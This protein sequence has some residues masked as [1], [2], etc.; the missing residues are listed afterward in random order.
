[1]QASD[2]GFNTGTQNYTVTINAAPLVINPSSLPA[3][4]QG[5]PYNQT[6]S[7]SGGTAPYSYTVL[8]GS[9]P[10][11][12]SLGSGGGITGTPSAAGAYS[13]TVQATDA[14]PNTG[15]RAYTI[16]VGTNI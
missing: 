5:A 2:P 11:G 9:L 15:T 6:V 13:F 4:T 3:G 12:L 8:S 7:A 14:T 10:P 16:N 1:M